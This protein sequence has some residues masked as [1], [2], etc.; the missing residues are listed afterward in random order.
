MKLAAGG[1][2]VFRTH[3]RGV[4]ETVTLPLALPAGATALDCGEKIQSKFYSG[5]WIRMALED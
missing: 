3:S 5:P 4:K 2:L 1:R